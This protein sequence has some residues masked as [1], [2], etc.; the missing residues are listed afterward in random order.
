M[1][2][3]V[4]TDKGFNPD[5]GPLLTAIPFTQRSM[6]E[7]DDGIGNKMT[8]DFLAMPVHLA[9]PLARLKAAQRSGNVMKEHYREVQGADIT[10]IMDLLPAFA[11][12][13][14]NRS[15]AR[16]RGKKGLGGNALLSNVAGPREFLY[17]GEMK[18]ENWI[19]T[20]QVMHGLAVNMTAWSYA[21][22][23]NL[24][25]LADKKVVPDGW[26]LMAYFSEALDEYDRLAQERQGATTAPQAM[27]EPIPIAASR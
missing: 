26:R 14:L 27:P 1:N 18:L 12:R 2:R 4:L 20:G 13:A 9:D 15:I 5:S 8:T 6:S 10:S 11:V 3:R 25:I 23:F 16:A 19:S 7:S 22:K 24:C 21:D 17:M